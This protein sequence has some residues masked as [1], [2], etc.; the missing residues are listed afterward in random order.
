[1]GITKCV[2]YLRGGGGDVYPFLTILPQIM[3]EQNLTID[4]ITLYLDSVYT[5]TPDSYKFESK[6]MLRMIDVAGLKNIIF[7]PRDSSSAM[8]LIWPSQNAIVYGPLIEENFDKK[9]F[10][11]WKKSETGKFIGSKLTQDTIFI[12]GVVDSVFEWDMKK[13]EYKQLSYEEVPLE[14]KPDVSEM[15]KI[16]D[17]LKYSHL[18]IHYRKKGYKEDIYY[19]NKI[20]EF[21]NANN[22]TPIII[23]LKDNNLV[24]KFMDLRE[25]LTV[26]GLFY[27]T[28][29]AK[30]MLTGSSIITR[31]RLYHQFKDKTTII[32]YPNHLGGFEKSL[33]QKVYDNP[34]H[35]FFNSDEDNVEKIC[36]VIK[37]EN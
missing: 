22:I 12:D 30:M 21:C 18:L 15:I 14:F 36:E 24:G 10:M 35:H 5:L 1:M 9:E 16:N 4:D 13:E 26:D 29:K 34:N 32:S 19:Y 17:M 33:K 25:E 27:I 11:F 3:E 6:T 28:E 20:I 8:D 31:H 37:N 7:V 2:V 23:G